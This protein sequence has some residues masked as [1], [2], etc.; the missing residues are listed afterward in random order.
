MPKKNQ[1]RIISGKWRGR[2]L[3]IADIEGLRPTGDRV[4]ETLFNWLMVDIQGSHC[5]DLFSGSGALG[6]ESLSR[7]A[8][9]VIMIEKN[10]QAAK[11]IENNCKDLNTSAATV[12][13]G[14]CIRW[15]QTNA[16]LKNSVD[17]AF[18]DPPF[19][20]NLWQSSLDSLV[21]SSLLNKDALIYVETPKIS[22]LTIT[23]SLSLTKE[24]TTGDV[25]YRLYRYLG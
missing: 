23:P 3:P 9:S 24:K 2:K 11:L 13:Q 21:S 22:K 7:G 19:A 10:K 17:I 12:V 16:Q 5:L 18:V 14:D 20:L 4:R 6:F 1:L 8:S 15:L 25:S